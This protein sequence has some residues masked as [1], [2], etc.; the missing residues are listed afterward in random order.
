M[1]GHYDLYIFFFKIGINLLCDK[2]ILAFITPH[3]F[4]QY[5]QFKNLREKILEQRIIKLS[6]KIKSVFE[7]VVLDASITILQKDKKDFYNVVIQSVSYINK[8]LD[9]YNTVEIPI[10]EFTSE[11]FDLTSISKRKELLK[12]SRNTKNLGDITDS[13]QGITVYAKVQ[14][15]KIN[16]FRTVNNEENCKPYFKGRDFNKY[17]SN[18]LQQFIIYGSHLW[19]ARNP[20]YFESPKIFLR[21]TSDKIIRSEERR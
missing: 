6:D 18:N 17:T 4:L 10:T 12:Y 15:E 19:C 20:K 5:T 16:H 1:S 21:Q 14:G 11:T 13:S 7:N 8:K 3:T 9:F 2:G